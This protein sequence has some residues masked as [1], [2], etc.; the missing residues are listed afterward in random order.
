MEDIVRVLRGTLQGLRAKLRNAVA[1]PMY[2]CVACE[3]TVHVNDLISDMLRR[4]GEEARCR[5]CGAEMSAAS[6]WAIS[7]LQSVDSLLT[8]L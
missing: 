2:A 1:D 7:A 5:K 6:E 8:L 4:S 3:A